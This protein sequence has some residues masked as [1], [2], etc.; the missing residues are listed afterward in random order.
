M[1]FRLSQKLNRK[2]KAGALRALSLHENPLA[3]WS[4]HLFVSDRTQYI[5]LSNTKSLD[6]TVMYGKGITVWLN[7]VKN[8]AMAIWRL[9]KDVDLSLFS[10]PEVVLHLS[11]G[12]RFKFKPVP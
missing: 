6:S 11:A 3:D 5:L 10:K 9:E 2:I 7:K 8:E 12:R 1:I 4:V